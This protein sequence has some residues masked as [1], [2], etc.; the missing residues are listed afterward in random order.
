[1][2][3]DRLTYFYFVFL[4]KSIAVALNDGTNLAHS[5]MGKANDVGELIKNG[6]ELLKTGVEQNAKF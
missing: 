1:M 5:K 4:N 6:G 3:Q 2:V